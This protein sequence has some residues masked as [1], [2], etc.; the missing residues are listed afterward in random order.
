[1]TTIVPFTPSSQTAFTF[2]ATL[3]SNL[4]NMIVPWNLFG[5]RYY[6]SCYDLTNNLIFSLPLIGS[7]DAI[8]IESASWV[9]NTVTITASQPHKLKVGSVVNLTI[10]NMNPSSFN[11]TFMC[12]IINSTQFSYTVVGY[13]GSVSS[14]G[15][16]YYGINI[17]SGYFNTS[18]I[19]Y[20]TSSQQFE[21]SP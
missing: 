11:G 7:T 3:D 19:I 2:Q 18:S 9:N 10:Y 4:Y 13:P 1:M 21:I 8:N 14:L 5:Q 6:L 20:R 15:S 17:A 16:F 12:Y